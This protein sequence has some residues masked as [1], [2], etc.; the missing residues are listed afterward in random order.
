MHKGLI[1]YFQQRI[2]KGK[3]SPHSGERVSLHWLLSLGHR[4]DD[5]VTYSKLH[6]VSELTSTCAVERDWTGTLTQVTPSSV[7]NPSPRAGWG[8][9]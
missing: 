9:R 1:S 7:L 6:S 8:E 5:G 3:I 2:L 4:Y